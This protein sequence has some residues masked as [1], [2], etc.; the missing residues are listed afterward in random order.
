M[1]QLPQMAHARPTAV[2]MIEAH[3][4]DIGLRGDVQKQ[5]GHIRVLFNQSLGGSA[6]QRQ[7]NDHSANMLGAQFVQPGL[8]RGEVGLRRH[9]YCHLQLVQTGMALYRGGD[10]RGGMQGQRGSDKPNGGRCFAGEQLRR[11]VRYV[12][13]R[14]HRAD[15]LLAGAG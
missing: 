8:Q 13:Q 3:A 7:T 15:Y 5:A 2:A 10:L 11:A 9:R 14:L 4:A 1:P 6:F 12:V